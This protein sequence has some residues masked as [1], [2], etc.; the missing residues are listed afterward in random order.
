MAQAPAVTITEAV[1][2]VFRCVI[3]PDLF[4]TR[5]DFAIRDWARRAPQVHATLRQ[6]D[7][8]RLAALQDMF[9]RFDYPPLEAVA[10]ARILYYM[11]IGYDDAQLDEPMEARNRLVP[12]YL[13]GFTGRTPS[14]EEVTA[15]QD[16]AR[17]LENP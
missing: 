13:I 2:N 10:R 7:D 12:A 1:G 17:A 4:D 3:N 9:A 6:S 11:Q 15:L 16:Y 14:Q 5:L 8:R